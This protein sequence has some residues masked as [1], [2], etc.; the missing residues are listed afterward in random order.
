V[1]GGREG[2]GVNGCFGAYTVGVVGCGPRSAVV[3]F[4]FFSSFG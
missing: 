3:S 4:L 2:F 1:L